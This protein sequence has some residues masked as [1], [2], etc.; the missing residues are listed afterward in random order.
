M[1]KIARFTIPPV[2]QSICYLHV[3]RSLRTMKVALNLGFLSF[4]LSVSHFPA[5]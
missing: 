1:R 3:S 2:Q 5:Y 4:L